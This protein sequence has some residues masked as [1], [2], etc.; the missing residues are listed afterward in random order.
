M[1]YLPPAVAIP[2]ALAALAAAGYLYWL[3]TTKRTK[4]ERAGPLAGAITLTVVGAAALVLSLDIL[5]PLKAAAKT[6]RTVKNGVAPPAAL[7]A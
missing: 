1:R 6:A 2:L 3:V 4:R 5:Q 7:F